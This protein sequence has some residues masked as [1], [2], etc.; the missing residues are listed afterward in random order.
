M[1]STTPTDAPAP[2]RRLSVQILPC[3]D[4]GVAH[5][6]VTATVLENGARAR[7][8][9]TNTNAARKRGKADA[10]HARKGR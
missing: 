9:H 1:C 5:E 7:P 4:G 10:Q 3:T 8:D 2:R 6:K